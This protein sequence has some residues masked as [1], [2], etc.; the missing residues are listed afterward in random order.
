MMKTAAIAL[1]LAA[2]GLAAGCSDLNTPIY[3]NSTMPMLQITPGMLGGPMQ[4][5]LMDALALRFRNPSD[6][7]QKALDAQRNLAAPIKIPWIARDNVHLE[8]MF[9][10]TNDT[11]AANNGPPRTGVFNVSVDGATEYIK[12]DENVV[13]AAIAQ[14]NNN[15]ATY[16]P[17]MQLMPHMLGPGQAYSGL[18]REDD[19][20][21]AEADLNDIDQFMAPFAAVLINRSDVNPIGLEMVPKTGVVVPAMIEADVTFT[22]DTPMTLKYMLRVRDDKDQLLHQTGDTKFNPTPTLFEPVIPANP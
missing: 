3:F 4:P 18:F 10:V 11:N 21:E 22:A 8:L 2:G 16:L 13:A 17:L 6:S 14:G 19:F 20:A 15:Q 12:Y 9:T 5:R 1:V 7:E